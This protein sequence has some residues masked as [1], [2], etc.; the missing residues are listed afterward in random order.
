MQIILNP[1]GYGSALPSIFMPQCFILVGLT[2]GAESRLES[3]N[4]SDDE[5]D[6]GKWDSTFA[7]PGS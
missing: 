2:R 4:L 3:I 6:L 5:E 1:S 7:R